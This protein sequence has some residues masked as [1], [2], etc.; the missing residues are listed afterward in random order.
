LGPEQISPTS[1][2][3]GISN[4]LVVLIVRFAEDIIRKH[5]YPED[6]TWLMVS[7]MFYVQPHDPDN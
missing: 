6:G 1:A 7:N 4:N 5:F 2:I 3:S